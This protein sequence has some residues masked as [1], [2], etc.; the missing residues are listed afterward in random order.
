MFV[1]SSIQGRVKGIF[2]RK[3]SIV[4][5]FFDGGSFFSTGQLVDFDVSPKRKN[6]GKFFTGYMKH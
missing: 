1:E 4:L 2:S 3:I 6:G 5:T